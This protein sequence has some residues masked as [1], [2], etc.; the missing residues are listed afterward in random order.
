MDIEISISGPE[1]EY[2]D[3]QIRTGRAVNEGEVLRE[4]LQSMM[5]READEC[6][7]YAEWRERTRRELDEAYE[8][9]LTD[10]GLDGPAVFE[11]LRLELEARRNQCS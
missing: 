7:T 3:H 2:I 5:G 9:S 6:R 8:E 10:E 11:E 1:M 4:A